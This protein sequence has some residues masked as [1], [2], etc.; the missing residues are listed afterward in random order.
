M[1]TLP[2]H[3]QVAHGQLG[4]III[5]ISISITYTSPPPQKKQGKFWILA[6]VYRFPE[7]LCNAFNKNGKSNLKS[8]LWIPFA[9]WL[10][11]SMSP[12]LTHTH[13]LRP[14]VPTQMEMLGVV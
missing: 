1:E 4:S 2:I 10:L 7:Y 8:K 6:A 3:P 13:L 12:S 14:L 9:S 5:G 11:R